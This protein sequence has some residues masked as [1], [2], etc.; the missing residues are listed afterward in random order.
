MSAGADLNTQ[1]STAQ[2][3]RHWAAEAAESAP[4]QAESG[5][6]S[7]WPHQLRGISQT[8]F[9]AQLAYQ[10]TPLKHRHITLRE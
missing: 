1:L 10:R 2:C 4:G 6:R 9:G 8:A 7:A 3:D 5:S